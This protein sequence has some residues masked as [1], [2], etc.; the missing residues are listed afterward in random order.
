MKVTLLLEN[1]S[2]YNTYFHAE[3]GFSAYMEDQGKKVL[4]DTAILQRFHQ[5]RRADGH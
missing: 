1:N 2:L 3:H 5:K 4:Y